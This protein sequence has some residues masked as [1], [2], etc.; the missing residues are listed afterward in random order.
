[1]QAAKRGVGGVAARAGSVMAAAVLALAFIFT[2][3]F[4][5]ADEDEELMQLEDVAA[6]AIPILEAD[7]EPALTA[8]DPVPE[9]DMESVSDPQDLPP[10]APEPDV[11]ETTDPQGLPTP[12]LVPT[13]APAKA[14]IR[15]PELPS[16]PPSV[17][18]SVVVVESHPASSPPA[19]DDAA[20]A[21]TGFSG[22]P[23]ALAEIERL[24][25]EVRALKLQN[26]RERIAALYNMGCVYK[27]CGQHRRAEQEFLKVL[28]IDPDDAGT[29][30]NLGI[31]Y[32]ESLHNRAKA[33]RHY[34][35]FI[36]L[37]PQDPDAGN[38]Q[39]WLMS[40]K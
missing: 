8:P 24:T 34:Q 12:E 5:R 10:P 23:A 22:L 9:S 17:P 7:K 3:D 20:G 26:R 16:P 36:E 35:R 28:A 21:T 2:S 11:A 40:L 4:V 19:L 6:S 25:G 39:A 13:P 31:L 29:H 37:A 15:P 27:V 14:E 1:M 30:Y 32:E 33:R 18:V 38:V